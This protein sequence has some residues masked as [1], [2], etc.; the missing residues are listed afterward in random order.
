VNPQWATVDLRGIVETTADSFRV[1]TDSA[2]QI[3]VDAPDSVR[4]RADAD[5]LQ[6]ALENLVRNAREALGGSGNIWIT[7]RAL[8]SWLG[9]R[10]EIDVSDDGPGMERATAERAFEEAFTTKAHGT[11]LGLSYALRVAEAHGGRLDLATKAGRGTRLRLSFPFAS[12]ERGRIEAPDDTDP[13][14]GGTPK[15]QSTSPL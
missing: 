15:G 13:L 12:E 2:I 8:Q 4:V 11:G 5:L 10:V 6:A 9:H 14:V 1:S 3:H 7:L